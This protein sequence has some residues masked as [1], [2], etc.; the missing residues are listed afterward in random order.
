MKILVACE[1]SQAVTK[2]LRVLGHEAYSCDIEPCSGGHPEW[3][4]RQDV[5]PLINGWCHF[6]TCDGKFTIL[7]SAWDMIIA[8]PPCTYLSNAGARHLYK[9]GKLNQERY[10]KGLKGKEFFMMFYNADCTKIAIENPIISS[11]FEM[12]KHTQE[13]QPYQFGHPFTKKTR[14]WL[15]GLPALRPTNIVEPINI[16]IWGMPVVK[17]VTG[18]TA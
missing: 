3:H 9:G 18:D 7:G 2:E 14:L 15:K 16:I 17:V 12:P 13:I 10:L 1:E 6:C 5:L 4:I 8:F 11:V